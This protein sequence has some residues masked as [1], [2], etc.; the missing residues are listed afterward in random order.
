MTLSPSEYHYHLSIKESVLKFSLE[1]SDTAGPDEAGATDTT[2][3]SLLTMERL[4]LF[5]IV[6]NYRRMKSQQ[7]LD[8][9]THAPPRSPP[10]AA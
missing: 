1:I 6:L 2:L 9:L 10:T 5:I 4:S 3:R 8:L 7:E